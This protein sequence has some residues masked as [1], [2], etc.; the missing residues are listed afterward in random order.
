MNATDATQLAHAF[1]AAPLLTLGLW[2]PT[3]L[4]ADASHH[5]SIT[6]L[7]YASS[8][9]TAAPHAL[10]PLIVQPVR[11]TTTS[12]LITSATQLV[13]LVTLPTTR[14][15]SV[16]RVPLTAI[17]VILMETASPAAQSLTSEYWRQPIKDVYLS[18]G[19]TK[20]NKLSV[21][22]VPIIARC[23]QLELVVWPVNLVSS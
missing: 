20:I 21:L 22:H 3:R 4:D 10:P 12:D 15:G 9:P 13:F 16:S 5:T 11:P 1:S 2:T 14:P 6:S 17:A 8:V 7:K 23:V 18:S 19:T